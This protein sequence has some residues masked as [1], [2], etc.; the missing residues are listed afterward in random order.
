MPFDARIR[1]STSPSCSEGLYDWHN[2]EP[3]CGITVGPEG[4]AQ[5]MMGGQGAEGGIHLVDRGKRAQRD[6]GLAKQPTTVCAFVPGRENPSCER[7]GHGLRKGLE[8]HRE[9]NRWSPIKEVIVRR[10]VTEQLGSVEHPA[11]KWIAHSD[12][13]ARCCKRSDAGGSKLPLTR[14]GSSSEAPGAGCIDTDR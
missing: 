4:P 8:T 10:E 2:D 9:R 14:S 3:F 13:K 6:P 5:E 11:I 12:S 1:G 7:T